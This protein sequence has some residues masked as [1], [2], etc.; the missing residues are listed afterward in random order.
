M[1]R[2]SR[3]SIERL[4]GLAGLGSPGARMVSRGK[5]EQNKLAPHERDALESLFARTHSPPAEASASLARDAFR[6]RI[7][8]QRGKGVEAVEVAESE[9]PA[10]LLGCIVDELT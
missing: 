6:Y 10:G 4:G 5:M 9:V 3:I 2:M 7:T 8:R 1:Q